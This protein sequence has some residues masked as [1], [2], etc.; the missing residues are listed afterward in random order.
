MVQPLQINKSVLLML[1]FRKNPLFMLKL[2]SPWCRLKTWRQFHEYP[3]FIPFSQLAAT[4]VSI[5]DVIRELL[6]I[7]FWR[8][9]FLLKEKVQTRSREVS[10]R[11]A[12]AI[13]LWCMQLHSV[14]ISPGGKPQLPQNLVLH[15]RLMSFGIYKQF[16]RTLKAGSKFSGGFALLVP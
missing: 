2:I 14:I 9:G 10:N 12:K 15:A 11:V 5:G 16:F 4:R 7:R 6:M 3:N 8:E 1:C 13:R